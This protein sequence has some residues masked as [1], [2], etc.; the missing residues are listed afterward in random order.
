M[1]TFLFG[2]AAPDGGRFHGRVEAANLT[3][4][5]AILE[6][7]E[8]REIEFHTDENTADIHRAAKSGTDV[9]EVPPDLW[10]AEDEVEARRRRRLGAKLW[11]AF[12]RHL[13]IFGPLLLLNTF[14]Y[15]RGAPYRWLDW[16][17]FVATPLYLL[18]FCKCVLP[19]SLFNLILEAAVWHEWARLRRLIGWARRLRKIMVTGIPDKELDI[20][21]AQSFAAEGRLAEGLQLVEKYRGH[22]D[23]AEYLFLN[24]LSGIYDAAGQYDR[25]VA[26][27]QEAAAKGPG[28]VSEWIDLALARI[29]RKHDAAGAKA[30]L[31]H[32]EGKEIPA[33]PQ[34]FRLIVE[35]MI[36]LEERDAVK[37]CEY[38]R[39]GLD[40]LKTAGGTP[41]LQA[42]LA[43]ARANLAI[44]L[45][46]SGRKDVARTILAKERALLEARQESDLLAR[47]DAALAA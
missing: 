45:A 30:A 35:G 11:A 22:P 31:A 42:F 39:A 7:R 6:R 32:L 25:V 10:S 43:E 46:Q 37:A 4:A 23:V 28:G 13:P 44:G 14:S 33:L 20:R 21:E 24:R 34:A 16:I 29:R 40:K 15:F 9:P 41:L 1:R 17:G 2:A 3:E 8:Y 26:L 19:M 5:R 47:C 38:L 12:Q 36:A 27:M 18:W